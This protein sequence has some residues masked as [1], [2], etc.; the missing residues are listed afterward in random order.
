MV[1]SPEFA[2][3]IARAGSSAQHEIGVCDLGQRLAITI[4]NRHCAPVPVRVFMQPQ[5]RPR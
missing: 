3:R 1:A 5:F 2:E 4:W